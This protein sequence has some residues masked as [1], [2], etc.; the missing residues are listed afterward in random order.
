M[1]TVNTNIQSLNAQRNLVGSQNALN[2]AMQ[3]LSSGLRINSAADDAAGLAISEGMKAQVRSMN[4]DVRNANDGVS[5]S[6]VAEGALNEV[7]NILSRMRELA[8]QSATGTVAQSQ[9]SYIN[10]EFGRLASEITRIA[11]AT[12]FNGIHL[13]RS[14]KTVTIQVGTGNNAYDRININLSQMDAGTLGVGGNIDTSGAAQTMLDSIDTAISKVS[15]SRANLGAVQN[16]FQ[17]VINNL[18]VAAQNTTAAQSRIA[19]ADVAS[20]T[21]NLTRAQILNQS[22]IAILAQANQLPQSALKLLG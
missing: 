14:S 15:S 21:A 6:Q 22:G 13:L 20:E 11:S 8:T 12:T 17:S 5:M 7:S 18:Q 9:R 3:R 10:S 4:Q 1:L 16:R 19:D 2:T